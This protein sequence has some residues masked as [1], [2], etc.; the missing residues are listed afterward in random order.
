MKLLVTGASGLL[1]SK[2]CELAIRQGIH[3]YSAYNRHRPSKGIPVEFDL[4]EKTKVGHV[5]ERIKPEAVV[6]A[7]A[8]TNVDKCE[9]EKHLSWKI[10]VEGTEVVA[11]ACKKNHAFLLYVSTDYVFDGEKGM[12]SEKDVT[13]PINYYG[14]TKQK[15]EEAVENSVSEFCIAR[16][17]VIYG[18]APATGRTNFALW[19]LDK[20]GREEPVKIVNDQSNSPTLNINLAS[21]ILEILESR[22]T[23]T[24]HL[25]GATR[26]TRYQYA[27]ALARQFEMDVGLIEPVSSD[28]IS[29]T[30][31]R[32]KDSSLNVKKAMQTLANKPL[33]I[34]AALGRMKRCWD[35]QSG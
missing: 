16:T 24:F 1:G 31:K 18:T 32:P 7:A 2:L 10:N 20:L 28:E 33:E 13:N 11:K 25:A 29:W 26:L 34:Q 27:T 15:G 35:I 30:A 17:S 22:L 12:Y 3:V 21:M 14:Y 23:G 4:S 8:L 6:H 5:V 19:L 9:A